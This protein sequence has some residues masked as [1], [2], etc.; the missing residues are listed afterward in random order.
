MRAAIVDRAN[1]GQRLVRAGLLSDAQLERADAMRR[2]VGGNLGAIIV[3]LGFVSDGNLTQFIS[4][5]EHLPVVDLTARVIPKSLVMRIPR[6]VLER[7]QVIP[8]TLDNQTLTLAMADPTDYD[9]IEEIQ[10][11]TNC[12]VNVALAS[13]Q[14]II[15]ALNEMHVAEERSREE[16]TR[17]L[18]R[19]SHPS[20][21]F[22]VTPGLE[23]ALIPLLV[24]KGIITESE[25]RQKAR[26]L[27]VTE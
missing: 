20:V 25:L 14:S 5:Q 11:L 24:E 6:D 17:E 4:E 10:F 2:Q 23:R 9:A 15:R 1:I 27:G 16:L 26:E 19:G 22:E 21:P 12:R 7:H 13:Q 3:K 8:V 18:E